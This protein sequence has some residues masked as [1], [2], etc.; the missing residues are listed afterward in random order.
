MV[1]ITELMNIEMNRHLLFQ[2]T[3]EQLI[4]VKLIILLLIPK[5]KQLN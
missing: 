1:N 5:M 2:E 3:K 4:V